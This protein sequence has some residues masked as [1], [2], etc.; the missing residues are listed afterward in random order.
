MATIIQ[1]S[2]NGALGVVQLDEQWRNVTD[3]VRHRM[4]APHKLQCASPTLHDK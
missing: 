1:V 4:L 3:G 2:D